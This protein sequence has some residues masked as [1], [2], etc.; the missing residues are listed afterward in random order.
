VCLLCNGSVSVPK[1]S[2]RQF[3]TNHKNFNK[4]FPAK[5]ELRKQKVKDLKCKLTLQQYV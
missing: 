2:K 4:E 3:L 1:K 5:S